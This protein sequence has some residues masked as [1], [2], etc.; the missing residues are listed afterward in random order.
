[1]AISDTQKL[2]YL[3][4]KLGFGVTKTDTNAQKKAFNEAIASPLLLR[5]DKLWRQADLIPATAPGSNTAV[6]TLHTNEQAVEDITATSQRTWKSGYTDWI[7]PEFGSTYQLKV[8][9]AD[10]GESDPVNNGTQLFA[11]GSG[12]NDE[13]F[14]DYQSGVLHFIGTN[15]PTA[16]ASESKRIFVTGFQYTGAFGVGAG[17]DSA[18]VSSIIE[19]DVDSDYVQARQIQYNTSDFLDSTTVTLVVDSAYVNARVNSNNFLDSSEAISLI[20]SNYVQAR[21]IQYNTSDFLDSDTVSLVVDSDYVRARVRTNQDLYTTSDVTFANTIITGDLTVDGTTT[22]INST[23]LSVNDKNLVLADSAADSAAA[24]GAGITI[25]GANA[26]IL[27][28][29]GT[30]TFDFNKKIKSPHGIEADV[31]GNVTGNVTG[32]IDADSGDI[33]FLTGREAVFDSA[34]IGTITGNLTGDVTGTV[35]DLS[36]HDLFDSADAVIL[37]DSAYV[38]ARVDLTNS[39]DS[40]EAIALI[41]S[42][43]VQ[44]RQIQ[45]NTSDFTDSA[46]VT[47]LAVS[48]FTNDAN[49]LDSTTGTNLFDSNYVQARQISYNT[50]DFLDSSTVTLVVDSAY[51]NARVNANNSLDSAE[52]IELI[53]SAYV[54]ARQIQY[55]TS[56]FTDSA[57]VTSRPISTF[58][59]DANYLDSSTVTGV[60]DQTYVRNNQIQYNTSDFLDSTTVTLVVDSAYVNARVDANNFTDSSEVIALI[61][62]DYVQARQDFAYS[63]L[64]GKPDFVDSNDVTLIVDSSYVQARQIQY[65]TSDFLDSTTVEL[66]V[67]SSYV[68]TRQDFRYASLTGAP[69]LIDSDLTTQ[70]IDSDYVRARVRTNQDL[71]TTSN[72][73]FADMIVSGNL[74]VDGTQT[75]INSTTL[76]VN[77][78]NLVLADSA[79][80]SA[81]ANGAGITIDGANATLTYVAATDRFTFNKEVQS[82]RFHGNLTG[83]VTGTVSDL[84]NHDLF[85]SSDATILV[86]SAYVQARQ[87]QYNTSDFLD[88]TTVTL[89][90]DSAYVQ[91]R[92]DAEASVDSVEVQAMIDSNFGALQSSLI[93]YADSTIDLGDSDHQFKDLYLSGNTIFLGG[94]ALKQENNEINIVNRFDTGQK[95][96]IRANNITE[97]QQRM[98]SA[99]VIDLIDSSYVQ[100]RQLDV[101]AEQELT[102]GTKTKVGLKLRLVDLGTGVIGLQAEGE[103]FDS[104]DQL[105]G[106]APLIYKGVDSQATGSFID[107]AYIQARQAGGASNT[108]GLTEGSSNLYYTDER[109]DD[110]INNLLLTDSALSATYDDAGN[111]LTLS[112]EKAT[113]TTIGVASFDSSNFNVTAA[114]HVTV[115]EIDGG[116]Y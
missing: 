51:V 8:Y 65:N 85:D 88:S 2:D 43:Y 38:N 74:T 40:A 81:A 87:I 41:D 31:T 94:I 84:S 22:T 39:L 63:S 113:T 16:I 104:N 62:S 111:T 33:R 66:V 99:T 42:A 57:F 115:D 112:A 77:D 70:L 114:G 79:A 109:V 15:L 44:A 97:G 75:I 105:S 35:S 30:D 55:N 28:Q 7:P 76:S 32:D 106:V 93:P 53:D 68:R 14:F 92:V 91:A 27:Y 69:A 20:D 3:F 71:Y 61:D 98:D 26:T 89:V 82:A 34:T 11:A 73:T 90:V 56:D 96:N 52:A 49:Y 18:S 50:S 12:N 5:A 95:L 13:W 24:N 83:D 46:F 17:T 58:T 36:N 67:D 54:Q 23:T 25:D 80:D 72:V 1:M 59:N 19:A 60:I 6:V 116:T 9:A 100:A 37:I 103:V 45:Y 108:D 10:S 29:S 102:D 110:R 107:S 101:S 21:Q 4:K 86:D 47:G 48:T 78:K 64:T